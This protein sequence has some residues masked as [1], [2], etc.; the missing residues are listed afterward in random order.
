MSSI[1]ILEILQ[2]IHTLSL[3]I[4]VYHQIYC[5]QWVLYRNPLTCSWFKVYFTQDGCPLSPFY[6]HHSRQA[7]DYTFI[8]SIQS[9]I[10]RIIDTLCSVHESMSQEP[11]VRIIQQLPH[12]V[13]QF[14]SRLSIN[15]QPRHSRA[16][17]HLLPT[18]ACPATSE[19]RAAPLPASP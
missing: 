3:L 12:T 2:M 9:G 17:A 4:C 5:L 8:H 6:F 19:L 15:R 18:H 13:F 10:S 7:P 11:S 14:D 1:W 16:N